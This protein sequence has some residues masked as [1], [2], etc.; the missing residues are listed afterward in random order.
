[1]GEIL[2]TLISRWIHPIHQESCRIRSLLNIHVIFLT[3]DL[4]NMH[5]RSRDVIKG[6]KRFLGNN[7]WLGW[8][9]GVKSTSKCLYH[10]DE[11]TDMQH[12]L[13]GSGH[14]LDLRSNLRNDLLG[15]IIHHSTRLDEI[16]TMVLHSFFYLY[17]IKSYC[18]KTISDQIGHFGFPWPL[19]VKPLT[20][21]QI[22]WHVSE[23]AVKG[24]SSAFF[25]ALLAVLVHELQRLKEKNIEITKNPENL[26]FDD[27][28]WPYLWPDLK[29]DWSTF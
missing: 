13:I 24:L 12:D 23:R 4:S 29:N 20:I 19:E 16:K 28:W 26:T 6:R 11:S 10:R 17:G 22:W 3:S 7:F 14:D 15:K 25:R 5:I 21:A 27:L 2:T 18:R 8:D 9:T 1:M